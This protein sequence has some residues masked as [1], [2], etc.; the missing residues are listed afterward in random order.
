[1]EKPS[2]VRTR[3]RF[4]CVAAAVSAER[5]FS[6][7]PGF[8]SS[9][10]LRS[11]LLG[12]LRLSAAVGSRDGAE[13][14]IYSDAPLFKQPFWDIAPIPVLLAPGAERTRRGIRPCRKLQLPDP[15]F[16]FSRESGSE[17][18]GMPPIGV[19]AFAPRSGESN[20]YRHRPIILRLGWLCGRILARVAHGLRERE[21]R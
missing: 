21:A 12:L 19:S 14:E 16:E 13:V 17:R 7:P 9:A 11:G 6:G 20:Q 8:R 1:M 4:F 18:N 2:R 3:R 15:Q 10:S 5:L